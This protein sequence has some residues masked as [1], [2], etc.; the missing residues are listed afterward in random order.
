MLMVTDPEFRLAMSRFASGVTVITTR[1]AA[2]NPHGLTVSAFCSLSAEPPLVLA[3]INKLTFS[4]YAFLEQRAFVVNILREDQEA[5]SRQ[6]ADP[7][8]DKFSGPLF[9]QT[10]AGLPRL[11]NCLVALECSLV[12]TH[13]GGDHTIIIGAVEKAEVNAGKPL[14]YFAGNY[15]NITE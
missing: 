15:Q 2:G 7:A 1:D 4:H 5:M 3:C 12:E 9:S 14:V 11:A 8:I 6:F 13:D 10:T